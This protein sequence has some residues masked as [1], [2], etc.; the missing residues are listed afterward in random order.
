MILKTLY[1]DQHTGFESLFI[2]GDFG[3][4]QSERITTLPPTVHYGDLGQ[5]GFRFYAD[6][7]TYRKRF[8]LV[9][10][11]DDKAVFVSFG[12]W[13]GAMLGISVNGSPEIPLPFPPYRAEISSL[14]KAGEN[15]LSV[16]VYGHRR[17]ALGPFYLNEVSP[18]WNG[19][20]QFKTCQQE[21][22]QLVPFGLLDEITLIN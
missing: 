2:L 5:Q 19:P 15:T 7:F 4:D 18:V 6:N 17:N 3:V 21:E 14:L 9:P 12:K 11:G 20:L 13:R 16:T 10:T 22:K 8:T 1:T